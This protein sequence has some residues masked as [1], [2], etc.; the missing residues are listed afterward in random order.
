[1]GRLIRQ[2][3]GIYRMLRTTGAHGQMLCKMLIELQLTLL[4]RFVLMFTGGG[5]KVRNGDC[6]EIWDGIKTYQRQTNCR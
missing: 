6:H 5:E 2:M 1:M 4:L 3:T